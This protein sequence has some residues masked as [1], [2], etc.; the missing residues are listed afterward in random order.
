MDINKIVSF[1][2][3]KINDFCNYKSVSNNVERVLC[4]RKDVTVNEL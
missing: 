2:Q 4:A 1:A 3:L